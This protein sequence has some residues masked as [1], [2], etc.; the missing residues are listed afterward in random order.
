MKCV[1]LS[2][3]VKP[4]CGCCDVNGPSHLWDTSRKWVNAIDLMGDRDR[5][6]MLNVL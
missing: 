6:F 2:K 3:S 4:G 5:L 1:R